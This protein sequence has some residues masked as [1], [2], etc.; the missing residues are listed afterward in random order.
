LSLR[1]LAANPSDPAAAPLAWEMR[2]LAY[3]RSL[4][5][6]AIELGKHSVEQQANSRTMADVVEQF[7]ASLHY[8]P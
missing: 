4:S 3:G 5:N 6:Q 7:G 2:Q 1:A 8:F